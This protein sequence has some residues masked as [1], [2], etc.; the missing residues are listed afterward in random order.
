MKKITK[1]VL[2]LL[3]VLLIVLSV[4]ACANRKNDNGDSSN[5]SEKD[6]LVGID[7]FDG[8]GIE[9]PDVNVSDDND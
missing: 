7:F 1:F 2:I 3:S 5:E 8:K 9:L 6:A 4:S